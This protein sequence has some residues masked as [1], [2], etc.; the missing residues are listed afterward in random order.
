MKKYNMDKSAIKDFLFGG[1]HELMRNRKY[2]YHSSVG[3]NYSHW[4]EEGK[5]ALAEYMN[6]IG[7]KMIEAE[8]AELRERSKEMVLQG[9]KGEQV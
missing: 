3:T 2:Y 1:I 6:L 7:Y 5:E 4:T 9:L 8:E